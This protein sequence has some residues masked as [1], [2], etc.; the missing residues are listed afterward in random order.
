[1]DGVLIALALVIAYLLGSFPSAYLIGR[2]RKGTDIREVGTRNMG[3]MNVFYSIGF[4][5]G[6]LVLVL[7]S[8]KGAAAVAVA[9]ALGVPEIVQFLAGGAA[10]LG[11]GYPVFLRFSGG[12]GGATCIG[13]LFFVMP[14]GIPWCIG[15]FGLM[16][17]ITRYPTFSYSVALLCFPFVGWLKYNR[18]ELVVFSVVLLL[19]PLIRYIPRLKEMR[20]K[21]ENWGHVFRRKS[22]EDRF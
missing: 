8:G 16:L 11:H 3:A 17:L 22:L 14:W 7:D 19:I 9:Y 15:I 1:M 6:I 5:W 12:K 10:V 13:I 21:A 20:G 2:L 18:W 4:W